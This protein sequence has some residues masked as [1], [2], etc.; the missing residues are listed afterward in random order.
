MIFFLNLDNPSKSKSYDKGILFEK[1]CKRIIADSGYHDIDIRVIKD[2]LEYDIRAKSKLD[3]HQLIGEAKAYESKIKDEIMIFISKMLVEWGTNKDTIG[4][5]IST[6]EITAPVRGH[7]EKI[8]SQGYK[9]IHICG[10]EIIEKLNQFSNYPTFENIKKT[11]FKVTNQK[12][13]ETILLVTDRG[14]YYVQLLIKPNDTMPSLF[15]IFDIYGQLIEDKIFYQQIKNEFEI[16]ESLDMYIFDSS[17]SKIPKLDDFSRE[18]TFMGVIYGK[19]W[20]DYQFPTPPDKFIGRERSIEIFLRFVEEARNGTG[21]IHTCQILSRSGVG[22][23]SLTIKLNDIVNLSKDIGIV[24]DSRNIRSEL[25]ILEIFQILIRDINEKLKINIEF[26]QTTIDI[27]RILNDV[28]SNLLQN[29][30]VAVIF[31]DQFESVF[32]KQKIYNQLLDLIYEIN[33]MDYNI[34]FCISRKNDQPTTYDESAMIDMEKLNGIS[35]KIKLDDFEYDDSKKLIEKLNKEIGKPLIKQLKEQV[36][37]ISGGFPWLLKK[38]C[39]HIIKLSKQGYTQIQISEAGMQLDD[40]FE[41]EL[42]SLDEILREFFERLIYFLPATYYEITETFDDLD[43]RYKLTSL[44]NEHRLIRLTGRTYDTYNDVLKEYVK[45]GH[46]LINRKYIFRLAHTSIL[47]IFQEIV[48]KNMQSIDDIS[49]KG[50][51]K[52]SRGT[53]YIKLNEMKRLELIEGTNRNF[54]VNQSAYKSLQE[55]NLANY[56]NSV[57]KKNTLTK[58]IIEKLFIE[59]KLHVESVKD[60]LQNEMQFIEA[61]NNVWLTYARYYCGWLKVAGICE[62]R[63][64]FLNIPNEKYDGF[65]LHGDDN[66]L[67]TVYMEQIERFVEVC[68]QAAGSVSLGEIAVLMKRKSLN[69]LVAA[70]DFLELIVINYKGVV[71]ISNSGRSFTSSTKEIRIDYIRG[72]ISQLP[73]IS[74]YVELCNQGLEPF[75]I[76]RNIV[77]KLKLGTDWNDETLK[78]KHKILR[79]WLLYCK[80]V[81]RKRRS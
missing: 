34:V 46:I 25:E 76:F 74:E 38:Y 24:I 19:G 49:E 17:L 44:Q 9:I 3:G 55:G 63:N 58:R 32:S 13:G 68:S 22:K 72:K 60:I 33:S 37:E 57:L 56:L 15:C 31:L 14:D 8:V 47:P 4:L 28:N 7:I 41:E 62:Y 81:K 21:K 50:K 48:E 30:N 67:P 77:A 11:S 16:L 12:S 79:N 64:N 45:T 51:R 36:L 29:N 78:W 18:S 40:L 54:K 80:M 70:A 5:F 2:N 69:G 10:E 66:Y 71:E 42:N 75:E 27:I 43:L 61:S 73:Y 39:A 1:L 35:K 26:P 65:V 23:S 52:Y 6:S 20:F 59:K 53:L